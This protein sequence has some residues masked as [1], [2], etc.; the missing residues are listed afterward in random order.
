MMSQLFRSA[1]RWR[2]LSAWLAFCMALWLALSA[3]EVFAQPPEASSTSGN[4]GASTASPPAPS[5]AAGA[6]EGL[7]LAQLQGH[8]E[9]AALDWVLANSGPLHGDTHAGEFRI[10][11]T[12]TPA[13]GWWDKAGG[14]KLAWHE[15][16]ANN[17]HLRI[18]VLD[19]ADGRL[20]PGLNLRATLLDAN[21]NEQTAPVDFGWYPLINA[22]GGNLPLAADSSYTLRVAI[23]TDAA[24][25]PPPPSPV[26]RLTHT[27]VA[28]FPSVPIVQNDVMLFPLATVTASA[29][30]A[31]LLKP[32]NAALRAAITA[33]WQQSASGAEKPADDYFVAYALDDLAQARPRMKNL[34]EF[35]G[36]DNVRLEVLVRDSRT[37]RLI[38][39][40]KP[41][42]S[43]VAAD[44]SVYDPGE[45]PLTGH[46]WLNH[47][48]RNLRI[49][50]K[51]LYKLRVS[52]DAPGFRR[53]G[54]QSVR[55][56]S[57]AEVEYDNLSL[58]PEGFKPD[59][60]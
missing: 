48:G 16:P 34:L 46:S 3:P 32:C 56:A 36:K 6:K 24:N 43:L 4:P 59:G 57:P 51:G 60:K 23:D 44:G 9:T 28:E 39:G 22:Y 54:P 5:A 10:A 7:R 31:E 49:P 55:F 17:V 33:L 15:A 18:F 42:A 12:V 21:G 1:W 30:E 40:L 11:F 47:Y 2:G 41:Q 13:E 14:G 53:W 37:G 38:P 52:F 26:E 58:I 8:A 27:T 20:V 19:L 25:A 45:L 29:N 50:R 35:S